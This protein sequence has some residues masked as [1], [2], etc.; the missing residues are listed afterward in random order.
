MRETTMTANDAPFIPAPILNRMNVFDTEPPS[1]GQAFAPEPGD[2]LL[3][4]RASIAPDDLPKSG[5]ARGRIRFIQSFPA[6][7]AE[8][9][10]QFG[11]PGGLSIG[12]VGSTGFSVAGS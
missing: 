3:H 10:N 7:P 2:D 9:G 11:P 4:L 6:P 8:L 12:R 1:M 5:S